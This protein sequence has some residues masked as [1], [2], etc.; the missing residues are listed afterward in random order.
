[1][2]TAAFYGNEEFVGKAVKESGIGREDIFITTKVWKMELG[3]DRTKASVEQSLKH[4]QTD[5]VDL[6]LIH[7]P[8]PEPETENWKELDAGSWKALEELCRQGKVRAIGV[9]NFL[10]HHLEAL[11]E[12]AEI[13]PAVNQLE[14]H[15][16]YTQEAAV[17]QEGSGG[18]GSD[19]Y[20]RQIRGI[21]GA[22]FA[23]ISSVSGNRGYSQIF[24]YEPDEGKFRPA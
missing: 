6:C 8:K 19:P 10:P 3:Y 2:D 5:Y 15:V 12:H 18:A 1:M 9:S 13:L 24:I 23:E 21:P 4:L 20:C 14:R 7:W 11:M 17:S 22:D 16:G